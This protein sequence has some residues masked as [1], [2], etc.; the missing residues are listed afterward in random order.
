M[1]KVAVGAQKRPRTSDE[2]LSPDRQ[3][4]DDTTPKRRPAKCLKLGKIQHNYDHN[5][6]Y[7]VRSEI[8][9]AT[10]FER[11]KLC[12]FSFFCLGRPRLVLNC[13]IIENISFG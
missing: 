12:I 13:I 2:A 7:K 3:G 1:S 6:V 10:S 9:Y 8:R 5:M 11:V 4:Q